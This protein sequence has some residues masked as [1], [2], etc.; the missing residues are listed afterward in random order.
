[1][2]E[3]KR[4]NARLCQKIDTEE[5]WNKAVNFIPLKGEI[6]IYTDN[7]DPSKLI[8]IKIGDGNS[9]VTELDF[10]TPYF[11]KE[12]KEELEF[13]FIYYNED[14]NIVTSEI[15][16]NKKVS[17]NPWEYPVTYAYYEDGDE[18][19]IIQGILPKENWKYNEEKK[20]YT[21]TFP[22]N[23]EINYTLGIEYT[24]S[25]GEWYISSGMIGFGVCMFGFE[26][27]S[28]IRDDIIPLSGNIELKNGLRYNKSKNLELSIDEH[29]LNHADLKNSP[30]I[31][32]NKK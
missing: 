28:I 2:A 1:M 29:Q 22:K 25:T 30:Y 13:D 18:D 20:C 6:I 26:N 17:Y 21:N 32:I 14:N 11:K 23:E 3:E 19:K 27:V 31:E 7:I 15:Y 16:V 8:G 10:T 9:K 5:N 24:P 4:L 12:E